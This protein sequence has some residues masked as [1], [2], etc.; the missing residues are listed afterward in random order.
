MNESSQFEEAF[1]ATS[2]DQY[3]KLPKG[4]VTKNTGK[5]TNWAINNFNEWC[6]E[7]NALLPD[8]EQCPEDLLTKLP[9]QF[10]H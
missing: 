4:F 5:C 2:E 7:R 1:S 3:D 10:C 6:K 8:Q 9:K